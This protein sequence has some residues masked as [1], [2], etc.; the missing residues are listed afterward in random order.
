MI[1]ADVKIGA[2]PDTLI[3][4]LSST[5]CINIENQPNRSEHSYAADDKCPDYLQRKLALKEKYYEEKLNLMRASVECQKTATETL[6]KI[7]E[8]VHE[9]M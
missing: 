5:H 6:K 2:D 1:E 9:L 4:P 8:A 3:D 7:A